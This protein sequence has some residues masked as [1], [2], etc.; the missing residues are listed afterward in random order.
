[1]IPQRNISLLSNRLAL[2][3]ATS[4]SCCL[5]YVPHIYTGIAQWDEGR[6]FLDQLA[7]GGMGS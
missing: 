5:V 4:L 2:D 6:Q 1:M 7:V 3:E